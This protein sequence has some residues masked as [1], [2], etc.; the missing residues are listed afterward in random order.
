MKYQSYEFQNRLFCP[1]SWFCSVRVMEGTT[2]SAPS[3]GGT[4]YIWYGTYRTYLRGNVIDYL[5]HIFTGPD[6]I[7]VAKKE[8]LLFCMAKTKKHA[9]PAKIIIWSIERTLLRGHNYYFPSVR[10]ISK[11]ASQSALRDEGILI[12]QAYR[13]IS[14]VASQV[15]RRW[16]HNYLPSVKTEKQG[17]V[18]CIPVQGAPLIC[19][20]W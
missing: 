19:P 18:T 14:K 11:E 13:L 8:T 12:F 16:G 1:R 7:A 15:T 3:D 20:Y 2:G 9:G 5:F 4:C 17:G 10:L 6:V